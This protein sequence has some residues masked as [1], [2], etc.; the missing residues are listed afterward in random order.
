[1]R[2]HYFLVTAL[3]ILFISGCSLFK[4]QEEETTKVELIQDKFKQK[5][6]EINETNT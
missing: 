5:V 4:K 3:V 2:K 6:K 1:M